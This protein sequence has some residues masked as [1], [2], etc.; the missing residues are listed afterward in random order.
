MTE[1][2]ENA[3]VIVEIYKRY[4][5]KIKDVQ[6][7]TTLADDEKEELISLLKTARDQEIEQ[8]THQ[9]QGQRHRFQQGYGPHSG[10]KPFEAFSQFP[11]G[12]NQLLETFGKFAEEWKQHEFRKWNPDHKSDC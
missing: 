6:N 2:A 12:L 5:Q 7:D 9:Q 3:N 1:H 10:Q 8:T 11:E 4:S